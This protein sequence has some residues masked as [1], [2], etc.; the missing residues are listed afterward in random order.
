MIVCLL[1]LKEDAVSGW[2]QTCLY[3]TRAWSRNVT[4]R[5]EMSVSI[6]LIGQ[7]SFTNMEKKSA[8]VSAIR[9]RRNQT[10]VSLGNWPRSPGKSAQTVVHGSPQDSE[11]VLHICLPEAGVRWACPLSLKEIRKILCIYRHFW[12][13]HLFP[14]TYPELCFR[15]GANSTNS[16]TTCLRLL[17]SLGPPQRWTSVICLQRVSECGLDMGGGVFT[18]EC[19]PRRAR[20][21]SGCPW[22]RSSCRWTPHLAPFSSP[23]SQAAPPSLPMWGCHGNHFPPCAVPPSNVAC[24]I[25]TQKKIQVISFILYQ[26]HLFLSF[27]FYFIFRVQKKPRKRLTNLVLAVGLPVL[28]GTHGQDDDHDEQGSTGGQDGYQGF[29]ICGLLLKAVKRIVGVWAA[30][31]LPDAA[32]T[33]LGDFVV[34]LCRQSGFHCGKKLG[35][36]RRRGTLEVHALNPYPCR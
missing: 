22:G 34:V 2:L 24:R 13:K 29:I 18:G 3:S 32:V 9:S 1:R 21:S 12:T 7:N 8:K 28:R 33:H 10:M 31:M 30:V 35:W 20:P 36:V 19:P 16:Y 27:L 6:L 14:L 4:T 25:K 5:L 26:T 17:R 11:Q 15:L 23:A